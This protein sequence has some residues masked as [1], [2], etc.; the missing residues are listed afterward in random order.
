MNSFKTRVLPSVL[1]ADFSKLEEEIRS[2]EAGPLEILHLDVMDGRF[3]P[4]LTFGPFIVKAIDKLSDRILDTHLMVREP[5]HLVPA[6][7]K[8]GSDWITVH[9]EACEDLGA[10][11]DVIRD[12][13][14]KPGIALNPDTPLARVEEYLGEIHLLLLMTVFPGFGGQEFMAEV[15][16]KIEEAAAI[17]AKRGY[18]YLIEVD[19]GIAPETAG[20]VTRAGAELLVAGS[21]VYNHEDRPAAM[22]AILDAAGA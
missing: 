14:A 1:S 20:L 15:V 7:A 17:R 13:G 8:A 11:L 3:V 19:G 2:V 6:F 21:A 4:N 18:D 16:P 22:R 12:A 5:A 9:V 10:T